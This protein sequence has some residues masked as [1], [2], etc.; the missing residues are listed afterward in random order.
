MEREDTI[1]KWSLEKLGLL[2]K[3][4]LA[5]VRVL[6]KKPWC[7]GYEYIDGFAGTGKPKSRDEEQYVSGSPRVALELEP[8]FTRYH[9]IEITDWRVKKLEELRG[10]FPARQIQIYRGDC[11]ELLRTRIIPTLPFNSFKRAIAFLDPYGMSLDWETLQDVARTRTIEVFINFPAMAINRNVR[12]SKQDE[13]PDAVRERMDRFWGAGWQDDL[14]VQE[15]T[16]FGPENVRRGQSP[17][18]LGGHYQRRLR[19]LFRHVTVPVLMTNSKNAPL[20]HLIFAG[21][22]PTGAKIATDIFGRFQE[23]V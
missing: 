11:N 21:D 2:R 8:P 16:L 4:L 18:E 12:R 3:Y 17:K 19:Q 14:F 10:E 6:S 13:I 1:G 15:Q 9:F 7:K 22:D 23:M 5:Y 20:Y